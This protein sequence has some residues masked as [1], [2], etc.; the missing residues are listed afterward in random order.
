MLSPPNPPNPPMGCRLS[1]LHLQA[2]Q[3]EIMLWLL[4]PQT[5]RYIQGVYIYIYSLYSQKRNDVW[6]A[7]FPA[8]KMNGW[9]TKKPSPKPWGKSSRLNQTFQPVTFLNFRPET[10]SHQKSKMMI[11]EDAEQLL[12]HLNNQHLGHRFWQNHW[13]IW[14]EMRVMCFLVGFIVDVSCFKP[15]WKLRSRYFRWFDRIHARYLHCT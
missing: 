7:S 8:C 10:A 13:K 12:V 6:N 9:F 2:E 1:P 15:G 3:Q 11:H 4:P 14:Y 5:N